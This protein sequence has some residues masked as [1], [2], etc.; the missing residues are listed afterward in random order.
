MLMNKSLPFYVLSM[1]G[2]QLARNGR[3]DSVFMLWI[4][5]D[6]WRRAKHSKHCRG[7]AQHCLLLGLPLN[8]LPW[9]PCRR[10][11]PSK[12]P[13]SFFFLFLAA[14]PCSSCSVWPAPDKHQIVNNRAVKQGQGPQPWY[15]ETPMRIAR[16]DYQSNQVTICLILR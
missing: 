3:K 1:V 14:S 9:E 7:L 8:L 11:C 10:C 4:R 5:I 6:T 12:N 13:P 16:L 2:R 15:S